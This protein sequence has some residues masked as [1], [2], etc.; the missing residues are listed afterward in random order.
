MDIIFETDSKHSVFPDYLAMTPRTLSLT[1]YLGM[2]SFQ[3]GL[4]LE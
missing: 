3:T 1:I 2:T 4:G